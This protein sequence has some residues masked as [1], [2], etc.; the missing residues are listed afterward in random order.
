MDQVQ[1]MP[2]MLRKGHARRVL[3]FRG[4]FRNTCGMPPFD[5]EVSPPEPTDRSGIYLIRAQIRDND[6]E[7]ILVNLGY[8]VGRVSQLKLRDNEAGQR[9]A[10]RTAE[11][12]VALVSLHIDP[13]PGGGAILTASGIRD[14][15]LARW[16][17]AARAHVVDPA[18]IQNLPV[19]TWQGHEGS[20]AAE[21]AATSE[22][23]ARSLAHLAEVAEQYLAEQRLGTPDPAAAIANAR[24]VNR[25]TVRSWIHRARQAGLL[26][27]A[28]ERRRSTVEGEDH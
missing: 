13:G 10:S 2:T 1:H 23:K 25:S 12:R 19:R 8:M 27:P 16:E 20:F 15:P 21:A 17:A 9:G 22:R 3:H 24:G 14:L 7:Q 26:L 6:Y 18:V 5:V 28:P 4:G 11:L